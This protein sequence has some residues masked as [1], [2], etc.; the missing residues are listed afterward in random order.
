MTRRKL[1]RWQ[2]WSNRC[3]RSVKRSTWQVVQL[4]G[5]EHEVCYTARLFHRHD[6]SVTQSVCDA[7]WDWDL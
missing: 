2:R 5:L 4:Y 6:R 3:R 1:V 7:L